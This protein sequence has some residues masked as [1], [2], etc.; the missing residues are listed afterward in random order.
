M[1]SEVERMPQG[2]SVGRRERHDRK[3]EIS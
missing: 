2:W 1:L 3:D